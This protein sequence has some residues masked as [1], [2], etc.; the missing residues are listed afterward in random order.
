MARKTTAVMMARGLSSGLRRAGAAL[1]SVVTRSSLEGG[2][3]DG[4]AS[5]IVFGSYGRKPKIRK[6]WLVMSENRSMTR[7][8]G[9]VIFSNDLTRR[10]AE[11]EAPEAPEEL[12]QIHEQEEKQKTLTAAWEATSPCR[13][14]RTRL[15]ASFGHAR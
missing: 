4:G 10:T 15:S 9:A 2:A 13:K 8:A 7:P 3:M 6:E 14:A 11:R 5:V 12:I 1:G